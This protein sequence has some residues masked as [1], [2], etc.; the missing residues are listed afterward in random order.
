MKTPDGTYSDVIFSTSSNKKID[1][2]IKDLGLEKDF[3]D[4]YHCTLT[5]SKKYLPYLKTSKGVKQVKGISKN[6]LSKLI[7]IK[8]LGHFD[9]D[10]GKNL[11]MVLDCK[12]CE[13]QF[14]RHIK[15]GATT[16]YP[17]YT[18]HTTLLYNCKDF[19]ID[20]L[21]KDQQSIVNEFKKEKLEIVEERI[22]PLNA[23]WVEDK[24]KD[25]DDIKDK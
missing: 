2:L 10:E 25:S 22:T 24:T 12:F 15:A 16:D 4:A 17:E 21:T 9:T 3:T 11:H 8:G 13:T 1:K 7:G 19:D 14:H 23:N 18:A 5:Y 20:K 6:E